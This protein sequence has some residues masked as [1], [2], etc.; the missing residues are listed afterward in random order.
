MKGTPIFILLMVSSAIIGCSSNDAKT[1][2]VVVAIGAPEE[3][4]GLK[5]NARGCGIERSYADGLDERYALFR[6]VTSDSVKIS[7]I[8]SIIDREFPSLVPSEAN[9][10]KTGITPAPEWVLTPGKKEI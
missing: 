2:P 5:P 10:Q 7:C 3:V 4:I 9:W 6:V 1:H 8:R